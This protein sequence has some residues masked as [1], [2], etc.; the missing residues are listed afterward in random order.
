MVDHMRSRELFEKLIRHTA[1]LTRN[2]Y[3]SGSVSRPMIMRLR[4]SPDEP[5]RQLKI[6]GK[7]KGRNIRL[8]THVPV[9]KQTGFCAYDSCSWGCITREISSMRD[10]LSTI[11]SPMASIQPNLPASGLAG[12]GKS[13]E[14]PIVLEA[15]GSEGRSDN[16]GSA[17]EGGTCG[18]AESGMSIE[19]RR[20][21]RCSRRSSAL[22]RPVSQW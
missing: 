10:W 9:I 1:I 2:K 13:Y 16:N 19:C 20:M 15:S 14:K 4:N 11:P 22:E 12:G 18:S 17:E 21:C 5:P 7:D 3:I 8:F 6:H